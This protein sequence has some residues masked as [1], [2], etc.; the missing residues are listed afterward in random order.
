VQFIRSTLLRELLQGSTIHH[1]QH[2]QRQNHFDTGS[3]I[4]VRHELHGAQTSAL[5]LRIVA[6]GC[7]R[8]DC[9]WAVTGLDVPAAK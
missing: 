3:I 2:S 1:L 8:T 5:S 4:R 7:H 6:G 9:F